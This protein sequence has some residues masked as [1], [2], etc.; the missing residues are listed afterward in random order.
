[1]SP[2]SRTG[3]L[4]RSVQA[5][6]GLISRMKI[7]AA[8]YLDAILFYGQRDLFL[9]EYVEISVYKILKTLEIDPENG[10]AY[11]HFHRDMERAFMA[12]I[13]TDRFRNPRTGQALYLPARKAAR[14]DPAGALRQ[15]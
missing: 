11:A 13:K 15:S 14:F 3:H 10:R 12:A 9:R 6:P 8:G 7:K 1:M 2:S 5:S 4:V